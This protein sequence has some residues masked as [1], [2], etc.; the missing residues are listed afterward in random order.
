M[1]CFILER[2]SGMAALPQRLRRTS[3]KS[4]LSGFWPRARAGA[5]GLAQI[6]PKA[7]GFGRQIQNKRAP[8]LLRPTAWLQGQKSGQGVM[9]VVPDILRDALG[10]NL[11]VAKNALGQEIE[12]TGIQTTT[13]LSLEPRGLCF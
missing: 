10:F 5:S 9:V 1:D 8:V 7:I 2:S 4:A 11:A 13:T 12:K 3:F 6:H